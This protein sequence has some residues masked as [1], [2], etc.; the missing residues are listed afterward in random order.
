MFLERLRADGGAARGWWHYL[1]LYHQSLLA[2][3]KQQ[4]AAPNFQTVVAVS[5]EVKRDLIEA[6]GVPERKIVVL[7]NGV[8]AVRFNPSLKEKWRA[9][10]R[11][12]LGVPADADLVLF[13]GSGFYRKGMDRLLRIWGAPELKNAF[14]VVVGDDARLRWYRRLAERQAAGRI[15]FV[16]RQEHV[17]RFYGAA[18]ALVLPS[19]Q[20]AFGNVVLEALASGVP[21]VV[22]RTV[23]AAELLTDS[24]AGGVVDE[25]DAPGAFTHKLLEILEKRRRA[26]RAAAARRVAEAYSWDDHFDRLE[27]HLS[28][29]GR[30]VSG[31]RFS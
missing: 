3:E 19:L 26:E 17:E 28:N 2:L 11:S 31:E 12:E 5:G 20:E 14:L 27:A 7:Y 9:V 22:S 24:L 6:Y 13:V 8:D 29:V 23:G 21:P 4:F 15:I 18:D 10:V 1:S 25:P 16:G 30:R